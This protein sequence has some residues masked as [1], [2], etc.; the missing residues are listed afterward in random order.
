M[1]RSTPASKLGQVLVT[2]RCDAKRCAKQEGVGV[3]VEVGFRRESF[4]KKGTC[5]VAGHGFRRFR[6]IGRR[7]GNS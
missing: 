1:L 3:G 2:S 5:L 4:T 7:P 6:V